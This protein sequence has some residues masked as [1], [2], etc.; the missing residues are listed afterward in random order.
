MQ[1]ISTCLWFN[2]QAEEAAKFYTSIF[3]GSEITQIVRYPEAGQEIHGQK[4]G[5]VMTVEFFLSGSKYLALNGGPIFQFNEATS[6]VINCETQKEID[7]FWEKLGAGGDPKAQQ[8]G[9]I[10]D[11]FGLSWQIVPAIMGSLF[12]NTDKASTNR[13]MEAMLKM[14]KL[15]IAELENAAKGS[16]V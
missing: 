5:S 4:V 11:K 16:N 7:F 12:T 13:V 8:C 1:K 15:N 6:Q 10:K 9:W 14:K 3:P 2:D